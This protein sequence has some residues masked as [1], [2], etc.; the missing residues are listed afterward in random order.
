MS[1]HVWHRECLEYLRDNGGPDKL[2]MLTSWGKERPPEIPMMTQYYREAST[3]RF[4]S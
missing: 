4:V 1:F 2:E 3:T